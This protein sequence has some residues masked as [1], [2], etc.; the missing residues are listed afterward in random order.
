MDPLNLGKLESYVNDF[1]NVLPSEKRHQL[2][3]L[4]AAH[5]RAT[6]EQVV[7]VLFPN[8][9]GNELFDIGM[10]LFEENGI[11][12]KGTNNGLL[13]MVA[14][15][16]KKI[17]IM[18]G[19]GM[20]LTYTEMV[21]RGII[22]KELRPLLNEGKFIELIE[23]WNKITRY[24]NS[25]SDYSKYSGGRN[26]SISA[27][28]FSA[29]ISILLSLILIDSI[30]SGI[31]W[32]IIACILAGIALILRSKNIYIWKWFIVASV[33]I[34]FF[35]LFAFV[36][37]SQCNLIRESAYGSKEYDCTRTIFGSEYRYSKSI[38]GSRSSYSSSS[39][40]SD[41]GSYSSNGGSSSFGGGG[42]SSNGGG[43]G[44]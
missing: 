38:G 24:K 28:F 27:Y 7:I 37:P 39:S 9:E 31:V 4:F 43:G 12:Q 6:T 20:D 33:P 30:P 21:C 11:W 18:T 41:G 34:Y 36:F 1:S 16:E 44:D 22:E 19:K 13:L 17:R 23:I 35:A 10:K 14:T 40:R 42:G 32:L 15:D 3:E 5:E 2:N 29:F 26:V 25:L 8:R